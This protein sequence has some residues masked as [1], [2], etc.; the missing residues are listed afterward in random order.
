METSYLG[1]FN[2]P[3]FKSIEDQIPHD[4]VVNQEVIEATD[5]SERRQNEDLVQSEYATAT[6]PSPLKMKLQ[7]IAKL[8]KSGKRSMDSLDHLD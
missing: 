3:T 8:E 1:T 5:K 2:E 7:T 4:L 6:T